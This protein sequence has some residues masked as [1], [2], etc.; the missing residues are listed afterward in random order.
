MTQSSQCHTSFLLLQEQDSPN[1]V[2]SNH[3]VVR[4]L[5]F[6]LLS[7]LTRFDFDIADISRMRH[8]DG[9]DIAP[10][11]LYNVLQTLTSLNVIK[12]IG[13][14]RYGW[15]REKHNFEFLRQCLYPVPTASLT[16]SIPSPT[17]TVSSVFS[18][19][20][21]GEQH[22]AASSNT[23]PPLSLPLP[24]SRQKRIIREESP[25]RSPFLTSSLPSINT[26][27]ESLSPEQINVHFNTEWTDGRS[28]LDLARMYNTADMSG[29]NRLQ[30][31]SEKKSPT[32]AVL[33]CSRC[34]SV[35]PQNELS[36]QNQL[37]YSCVM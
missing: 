12:R 16:V 26:R 20:I 9:R 27:G 22:A 8:P 30:R 2:K 18:N 1:I 36:R 5:S 17:P 25:V 19:V 6:F 28:A 24:I 11:V 31:Q 37:C 35:V 13:S 4:H 29:M 21:M 14:T 32:P 15:G 10:K 7:H 23:L 3:T 33:P 34:H